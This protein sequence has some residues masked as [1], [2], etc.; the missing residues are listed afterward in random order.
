MTKAVERTRQVWA[1][2]STLAHNK[3]R[4]TV[5]KLMR[6]CGYYTASAVW[7]QLKKLEDAGYI[8]KPRGKR[9]TYA[10]WVVKVPL[11]DWKLIG[12][13]R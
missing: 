4:I 1:T 3:K 8:E 7:H 13:R 12:G 11:I 5:R 2:A 10:D 9:S 6:M